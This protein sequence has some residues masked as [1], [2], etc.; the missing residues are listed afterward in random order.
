MTLGFAPVR[1]L[2][3]VCACAFVCVCACVSL[4]QI[5]SMIGTEGILLRAIE[6]AREWGWVAVSLCFALCSRVPVHARGGGR[7]GVARH[8]CRG[9][10]EPPWLPRAAGLWSH[11]R[12]RAP[13]FPL[14]PQPT[15]RGTSGD[16]VLSL[17]KVQQDTTNSLHLPCVRAC[18]CGGCCT[19]R[20]PR[21]CPARAA[22]GPPG[23]H[24]P[25]EGADC[26][27]TWG[28]TRPPAPHRAAATGCGVE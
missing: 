24:Q 3:G 10:R 25:G 16:T 17:L 9:G 15:V 2:F 14:L 7:E 28:D 13:Q 26:V 27:L 22:G 4:P 1:H 8:K 20:R 18:V 23:Q 19:D 5:G 11:T 6:M 21:D 12:T